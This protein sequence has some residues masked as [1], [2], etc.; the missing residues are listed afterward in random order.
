MVK[1]STTEQQQGIMI[2]QIKE[3]DW[4]NRIS[5]DK[6]ADSS[7]VSLSVQGADGSTGP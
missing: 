1:S 3:Q 7:T 5:L 2:P 4:L 6:G